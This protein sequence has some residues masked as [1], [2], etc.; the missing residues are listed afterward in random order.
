MHSLS[1]TKTTVGN[2]Q[3]QFCWKEAAEKSEDVSKQY[4][5]ELP[6]LGIPFH[7]QKAF[8]RTQFCVYVN[9]VGKGLVCPTCEES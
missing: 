3:E 9:F 8:G 4:I 2:D 1:A 6:S 5:V 7:V